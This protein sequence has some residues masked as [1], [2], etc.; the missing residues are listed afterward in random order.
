MSTQFESP[1]NGSDQEFTYMAVGMISGGV[2]GVLI[3]LLMALSLGNAAMWVSITGGIGIIIGLVVAQMIFR[4]K[5][6]N[7]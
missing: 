1:S 7:L 6:K 3:G 2:P 5:K 4:K